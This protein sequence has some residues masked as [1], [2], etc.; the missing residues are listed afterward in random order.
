MKEAFNKAIEISK[1]KG[2]VNKENISD[3]KLLYL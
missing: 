3:S 2:Q 1:N